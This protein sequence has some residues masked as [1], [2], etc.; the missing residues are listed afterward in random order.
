MVIGK[1][2]S[3]L[4]IIVD[5]IITYRNAKFNFLLKRHGELLVQ[6][7]LVGSVVLRNGLITDDLPRGGANL[8][9]CLELG[10][11]AEPVDNMP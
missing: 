6:Q 2:G 3:T 9:Q 4:K 10:S 8:E 7:N 5:V 1:S 11:A